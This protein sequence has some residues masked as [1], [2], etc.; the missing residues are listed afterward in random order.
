MISE[1]TSSID[2]TKYDNLINKIESS[3]FY[4]SKNHLKF[5]ESMLKLKINFITVKEKNELVGVM[6]FF[7]KK[8]K[9]G[10]VI[11]SLPFFGSYG[12]IISNTSDIEV[13]IIKELN[14]INKEKDILSSVIID[15][16]FKIDNKTFSKK[17]NFHISEDRLIQC[18]ILKNMKTDDLW[19]KFEQRVRRSVRKSE[20]ND[21]EIL[22][23]NNSEKELEN[24]YQLHINS[25][26]VKGGR[27]KPKQFFPTLLENFEAEKDYDIFVAKKESQP[28]A[29]L[30]IF[31][32]KNF[33]EY[34]MP[35]YDPKYV[36]IQSTSH[37]IWETMK[38]AKNKKIQYYNFG[39]T[40]KNQNEL[41][42]FKRGWN[43]SDFN[44][45][46][47]IF[48]DLDRIK[49]AGLN[50]ILKNYEYFYVC[51]FDEIK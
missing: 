23:E 45:K 18:T 13:Q 2:F 39:G 25:M 7:E 19:K 43:A 16:P 35:A 38:K 5:L 11:N 30:L 26:K 51:P 24:F 42:R 32:N 50:E 49:E 44:Y 9:Y 20:K 15:N 22:T 17:F 41:Y 27:I 1:I 8:E 46:Y 28:I 14:Q 29:Y 36:S 21:I 33:A 31:Y 47:F 12:G 6:P 3:T 37:L 10:I 34:Y 48:R 4:H 40:W